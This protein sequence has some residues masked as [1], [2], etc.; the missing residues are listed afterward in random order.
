MEYR[1]IKKIRHNIYDD[2]KEFKI[3]HPNAKLKNWRDA[4]EGD[5]VWSD[6][7]RIVQCLIN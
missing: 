6:D 1:T 2:E 3:D 4:D 7:N 5:W